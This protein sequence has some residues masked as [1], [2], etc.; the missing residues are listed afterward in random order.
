MTAVVLSI[1]TMIIAMSF[2]DGFQNEIRNKVFSFWGHVHIVPYSLSKTHHDVGI[3][4]STSFS[5][6]KALPYVKYLHSVVTKPCL[7]KSKTGF[8][9]A[10]LKGVGEDYFLKNLN[11]FIVKG[12]MLSND[13][14]RVKQMVVSRSMAKRLNLA[15]DDKVILHFPGKEIQTRA[16]RVKGIYETGVEEFD[17]EIAFTD[18]S[19][20]Q[21]LNGWGNDTVSSFELKLEPQKMFKSKWKTYVMLFGGSLLSEEFYYEL[22]KDPLDEMT[23][24]INQ[25]IEESSMEAIAVK[26]IYPGLFDWLSLQN[27]NELIIIILMILVAAINMIS[28]LLIFV[29]ERTRMIGLLKSVGANDSSLMAIF[30]YY[31]LFVVVVGILLGNIIGVSLC[32]L[33]QQFHFIKLPMDSYY[34]SFAPISL[35]FW[36]I[37]FINIGTILLCFIAL[38]LPLNVIRKINPVKTIQFD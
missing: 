20:L 16:L 34:L 21:E 26:D 1:S 19:F 24:E 17:K 38:L 33:Q 28:A 12:E 10:V 6:A 35:S 8:D 25:Q 27:M 13:S 15:I 7:M 18:I 37:L 3:P 30:L 32:L 29:L 11:S 14:A 36:N 23:Y 31:G 9:G 2:I 22:S 4:S 5:N